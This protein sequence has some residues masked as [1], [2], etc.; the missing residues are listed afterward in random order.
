M[1]QDPEG[2]ASELVTALTE[3]VS[4][5]LRHAGTVF[6]N[7]QVPFSQASLLTHLYE[8]GASQ[9]MSTLAQE[10]D[11]APRTVTTL[12]DG[13]ERRGLVQR[14]PDPHDRRA[15]L[16]SVTDKGNT[17]MEEIEWG[18]QALAD[19]LVNGLTR[20]ERVEFARLL[21][22]LRPAIKSEKESQT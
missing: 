16:V 18:R 12:V 17:L 6:A 13:L 15:V 21:N 20:D 11:V 7:H 22:K 14:A 10:F 8:Q 3:T 4:P 9:R 2:T 5:L 1:T 19:E